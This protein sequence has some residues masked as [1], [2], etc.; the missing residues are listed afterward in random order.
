MNKKSAILEAIIKNP[1]MTYEEIGKSFGVTRSWVQAIAKKGGLPSR[2]ARPK[3][4]RRDITVEKVLNLYNNTN[5]LIKEIPL[6]L[7]CGRVT[8][9]D[10]LRKAGITARESYSRRAKIL[11]PQWTKKSHWPKN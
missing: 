9:T 7:G 10:R 8:V 3:H 5:L 11:N 6:A 2:K 4:Y 1:E